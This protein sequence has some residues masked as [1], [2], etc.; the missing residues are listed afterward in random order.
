MASALV[1]GSVAAA[2]FVITSLADGATRPGYDARRHTVSA[3]ATGSRGWLQTM[4]FVAC[5][6]LIVVA[7]A[8][9]HGAAG[10]WWLTVAIAVFGVGL[11]A[12]GVFPMDPMRG[13]PP[14]TPQGDPTTT[15]RAHQLHDG[16]GA[17]VFG[18]LPVCALIAAST[19]DGGV[20]GVSAGTAAYLAV[21]AVGFG[22]AWEADHPRT[23]LV[24]RAFIVPGWL[25]LS[26]LCWHLAGAS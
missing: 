1:A 5:G 18:A 19:L 26:G 17:V 20:A 21:T 24:Q 15:S 3:L 7:A 23:G 25:W 16:A 11:I 13:Y 6:L 8:G 10:S 4:N 9:V 22:A 12:S 2:L 14:G